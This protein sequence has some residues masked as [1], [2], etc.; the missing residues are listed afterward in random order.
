MCDEPH[1]AQ[2][3]GA[4]ALQLVA[5]HTNDVV[6][7]VGLDG[8]TA[9]ISPSI[10][11]YGYEPGDIVGT[12]G[13]HLIHPDDREGF[14]ANG[15]ALARGE[16]DPSV[17]RLHRMRRADGSW[18][19]VEGNPRVIRDADGAPLKFVNVFR[20]VSHRREAEDR[21]REHAELFEAA[22]KYA[23]IG[24][25]LVSSEG[26][27]LRVND[28]FCRITGYE[29]PEL[30]EM[31]IQTLT[32]PEDLVAGLA[33]GRRLLA[34]EMDSYQLDKRY[35]RRDG[36]LVWVRL[37]VA[38]VRHPDGTPKHYVT[39]AQDLSEQRAAEAAHAKSEALYRLIAENTSDM[40]VI[41][42]FDGRVTYVSPSSRQLG[43]EPEDLMGQRDAAD[44]IHPEDVAA[45]Q[46]AFEALRKGGA[47]SRVRW[48]GRAKG[49]PGWVWLE[50]N[51]TL[52]R[53]AETGEA[54]AYLDVIRD[55]T[56]QVAQEEAVAQAR[57]EAE[58]AAAAKAQFLAN[59]SHE[60]RTP[61]TAVLGFTGLLR[62][63][64]TVQGPAAGY[65]ARIA[66][67][68][69]GL[70]AIVND[71]L[72]FSKLEAG[73]FEIRP[74]PTRIA[75]LCEE[76][77]QM[78]ARQAGE[79]GL[80]LAFEAA[81]D[82]PPVAMVDGNRLR[83][84]LVNLVGNAVKFT[85]A[86]TVA[87]RVLV[88]AEPGF[89]AIEVED[90]GPGLDAE[91]Q[92]RLFQRFTQIDGSMTRRHGGTG[93]GL[94]ISRGLAEAMGGAIGVTS[95]PGAGA[96]FRMRVAAPPAELPEE[97]VGEAFA[98]PIEGLRVLVVEDNPANRELA[99]RLLEAAGA[100]VSEACDGLDALERLALLPVDVVLMD[101]R[102]PQLDGR[103]A[104]GRLRV[105]P[106][107]NVDVPVLAFTADADIS[108]EDDLAGFDGLVRKPIEPVDMLRAL[109]AAVGYAQD[110]AAA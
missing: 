52:L 28:A 79:K 50:S 31:D 37:N 49:R 32:L 103:G 60:I 46:Q 94:A 105:E 74:T 109:A 25:A 11:Q 38:L 29:A 75:E 107:P 72:D 64:P 67:A 41:S 27:F 2:I 108:G 85:D 73:K 5:E 8:K 82:L 18:A 13:A 23:A 59:M 40:I 35:I 43:W 69:N 26:A 61:L 110:A 81:P 63:D 65:V 70:L 33:Y 16:L 54:H 6:V 98:S 99:R 88:D 87:M 90:T 78:F 86:G 7:V 34:G 91:A 56:Q 24:K 3:R 83:Q 20:D 14:A 9:Y 47:T 55:V 104:L 66:G 17:N 21:A 48:R 44:G 39:Q 95:E 102:M 57:A 76:T 51:P 45:V 10:R 19:W 106:G 12:D 96:C 42:E 84:A 15:A 30:L 100:E 53:D 101:L 4:D 58:A 92:A 77:L 97:L 80:T 36:S 71:V 93:L 1:T 68:G 62:D 89:V 22:F